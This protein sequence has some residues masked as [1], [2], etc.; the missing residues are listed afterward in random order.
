MFHSAISLQL[1]VGALMGGA[2]LVYNGKTSQ[3]FPSGF[4]FIEYL[5]NSVY[6]K[7]TISNLVCDG[8]FFPPFLLKYGPA[9][10]N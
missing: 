8:K 10:T 6:E 2:T 1:V 4:P 3:E 5:L 7:L 9:I